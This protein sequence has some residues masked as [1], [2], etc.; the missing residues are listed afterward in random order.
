MGNTSAGNTST[1]TA[2]ENESSP[3]T[4]GGTI[5]E[6]ELTE[7]PTT[8]TGEENSAA[9]DAEPGIETPAEDTEDPAITAL[10]SRIS[11]LELAYAKDSAFLPDL[12]AAHRELIAARPDDEAAEMALRA[13]RESATEK[14]KNLAL[15]GKVDLADRRLT[16]IRHLFPEMT[17]E[18][19]AQLKKELADQ[20]RI[21]ALLA[22]AD[23]YLQSGAI[24]EPAGG[25]ALE[26]YR[27]VLALDADNPAATDG[28]ATVLNLMIETM[29][30]QP[31]SGCCRT[32]LEPSV[33]C[34]ACLWLGGC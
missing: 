32:C 10:R 5:E 25:N 19:F 2:P 8:V 16:Q 6:P 1:G 11:S 14:A 17:P 20:P 9:G 18:T 15:E 29:V 4:D 33:R 3:T 21:G 12:V 13:L 28:L 27:Q 30:V 31:A 34:L 24:S 7:A 23:K 22:D 26:S